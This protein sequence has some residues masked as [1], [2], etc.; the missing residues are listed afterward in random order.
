MFD[1]LLGLKISEGAIANMLS[2]TQEPFAAEADK[3]AAIVRNSPVIASDETP[4]I[5][6]GMAHR[7]PA[8]RTVQAVFPHT[9][10]LQSVVSSSGLSR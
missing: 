7:H 8:L 4:W 9:A 6:V 5:G 10:C 2:R 3:I 1:G